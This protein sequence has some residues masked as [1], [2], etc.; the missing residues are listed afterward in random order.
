VTATDGTSIYA[1]DADNNTGTTPSITA[2]LVSITQW[3]STGLGCTNGSAWPRAGVASGKILL[4]QRGTCTFV[5]KLQNAQTA[6]AIAV[7]VYN[8]LNPAS[9]SDTTYGDYLVSM[10][11]DTAV[12]L[13]AIANFPALFIGNTD[14][15]TL[16][17]RVGASGSY[18]VTADFGLGAGDTHQLAD[19]SGRG[20]IAD[21]TIKPDLVA[22]GQ[23]VVTAWCT[24][25]TLDV[26]NNA[27]DAFGFQL[28]DGTSFSAPLTA[29][30]IA[31]VKS[32]RPGLTAN[33]YRSLVVNGASPMLDDS[34]NTWPVMSAGAGSLDVLQAVKSTVT[35]NPISLSFGTAG[36]SL[37]T[38]QQLTL[39]NVGTATKTY[40]LSFEGLS[41]STVTGAPA[42]LPSGATV[43]MPFPNLALGD[44]LGLSNQAPV[45]WTRS[46]TLAAGAAATVTVQAPPVRTTVG[47][48]QGFI[49]V[50]PSGSSVPDA[51]IPWWFAVTSPAPTAIAFDST[52]LYISYDPT[53]GYT[54]GTIIVRFVDNATGVMLAAPGPVTVTYLGGSA[55]ASTPYQATSQQTCEAACTNVVFP[56]VWLID[57]TTSPNALS[58]DTSTFQVT[59]GNLTR[60]F[61]AIVE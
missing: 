38:S 58:G 60:T 30:A 49:D 43:Y 54:D 9:S 44:Y 46:V 59:S 33:D 37:P 42:T 15:Q 55:V 48:Y 17:S 2:P 14:G 22:A 47:A 27:C 45:L 7:V 13:S 26:N 20:P 32:A 19:F 23:S 18:T 4:I 24:V 53:T 8:Y 52:P 1:A 57:I 29:G 25:E 41:P 56:N 36:S 51:R 12:P 31:L 34:G 28:I 16:V 5:E 3:D 61:T 39:K 40:N 11:L 50:T 21:L 10:Y 6:G 35:A